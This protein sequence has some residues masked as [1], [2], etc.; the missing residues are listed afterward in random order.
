VRD[1][2]LSHAASLAAALEA[3]AAAAPQLAQQDW[4]QLELQAQAMGQQ[5]LALEQFI[6]LNQTGFVKIVKK[7]DK[8]GHEVCQHAGGTHTSKVLCTISVAHTATVC[9][10]VPALVLAD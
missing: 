8:V 4:R 10:T 5:L 7:H 2:I 9:C 3:L 6:H 1:F